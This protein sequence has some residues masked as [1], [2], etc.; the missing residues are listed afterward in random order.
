MTAMH[1]RLKLSNRIRLHGVVVFET[2]WRIGSGQEGQ[3]LSD[4][5]VMLSADGSPLLPGSS[6][7]GKLRSTAETLA[8]ALNLK[9]C[10]LDFGASQVR[11]ASDVDL[12]R[13]SMHDQHL[14][15]QQNSPLEKRLQ[16]IE[17]NTC[18]VCKLFGS[19]LQA[20]RLRI[21]DGRL[22]PESWPGVVQVRDSVVI[23]RDSQTAVDGLKF[24]Y[25]VVPPGARFRLQ[26]DLENPA[27][28][29]LALLGAALFDWAAG[30]SIGGFTSRG[31]GRAR[32]DEVQL[33]G[34]DF[35]DAQQKRK[36]LTNVRPEAKW[37][38]L[39][40]WETYFQT[41]IEPFV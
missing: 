39:G 1:E 26:I 40:D 4:L 22:D 31:L 25:E 32:L 14:Q 30:F 13:E 9:A 28:R 15:L 5:G 37:T 41:C 19:P 21:G 20:G 11:C 10:M 38:D 18:D 16:W 27:D 24:D 3:T 7:K 2:G 36:Y 29:E 23:D 33:Q 6:L 8:D 34:V 12:Y 17:Q 35:S